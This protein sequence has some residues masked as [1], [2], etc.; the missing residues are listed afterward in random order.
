MITGLFDPKAYQGTSQLL[1]D[2]LLASLD[3][4]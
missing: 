1:I 2:R 4:N 3:E